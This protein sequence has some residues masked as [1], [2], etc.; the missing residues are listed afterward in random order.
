M[1]EIKAS[2]TVRCIFVELSQQEGTT[3]DIIGDQPLEFT[4]NINK[5][6]WEDEKMQWHLL[7]TV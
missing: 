5:D 3:K 2:D 7:H 4:A 1:E 6:I